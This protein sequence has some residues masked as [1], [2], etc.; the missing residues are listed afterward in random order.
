M[1]DWPTWRLKH[2]VTLN[3]SSLPES[4]PP[5]YEFR[6]LE[7]SSV[8]R[9]RL[10]GEP[11]PIR[12]GD[13][14][15]RARR[16]VRPGDTIVSTVRTYLRAVWPVSGATEEVVV[17]TGFA[18]LSPGPRLDPEFFGWWAQ[19]DTFIDEVVARSVGV[20]YPAINAPDIGDI[21]I[22]LPPLSDQRHIAS[23]LHGETRKIDELM[24]D[25]G[26]S[27]VSDASS[28][29]GL[30]IERR[31]TLVARAVTGAFEIPGVAA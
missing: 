25:L 20:A 29:S 21:A 9:G 23:Y 6:Y 14:P 3:A 5:D 16:L 26:G 19:S 11:E 22:D 24:A 31:E 7:I 4:T 28:L 15:S 13:A 2:L 27:L 10:V 12:F 30:L 8:G 1:T 18:V 17:S